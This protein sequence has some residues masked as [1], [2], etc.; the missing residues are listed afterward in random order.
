MGAWPYLG[1]GEGMRH[2]PKFETIKFKSI[3]PIWAVFLAGK[4]LAGFKAGDEHVPVMIGPML[5]RIESN[6]PFGLGESAASNR[7]NSTPG[8]LSKSKSSNDRRRLVFI[9][10]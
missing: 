7:S 4:K 9:T 1:R 3:S 6:H 8:A 2:S 10:V 5:A